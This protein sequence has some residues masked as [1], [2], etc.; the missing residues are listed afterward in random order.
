MTS[1]TFRIVCYKT[2]AAYI[3]KI[4]GMCSFTKKIYAEHY[5]EFPKEIIYLIGDMK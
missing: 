3:L 4:G 5:L 2:L 1:S